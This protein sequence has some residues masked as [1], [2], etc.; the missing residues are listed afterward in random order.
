[1]TEKPTIL[2]AGGGTGG[3]L[4]PGIAVAE[5]LRSHL[6]TASICFVGSQRHLERTILNNIPFESC[7]IPVEPPRTFKR[8]P[9]RFL[10]QN[11]R[12]FQAA[13][14][15]LDE[16][17]PNVVVGLGSYIAAPVVIAASR[18]KIPVVLLEQNVIPGKA[19]RFLSRWA[20]TVCLAF[21]E[22]AAWFSGK[23]KWIVTGNPIRKPT[24]ENT[25]S[26]FDAEKK[27]LLI[28]GGSQGSQSVNKLAVES[29]GNLSHQ[30]K[31]WRVI[32]QTG[33]RR[34]DQV[35]KRYR[36]NGIDAVVKEFIA[37]LPSLFH[38]VDFVVSRAG[39]TTLAELSS[40]GCPTVLIPYPH[41]ANNHQLANAKFYATANAALI[42]E[43]SDGRVSVVQNLQKKIERLI[44]DSHLR[45]SMSQNMKKCSTPDATLRVADFIESFLDI[46]FRKKQPRKP[47]M[48]KDRI[49]K[50]KF[51]EQRPRFSILGTVK[52][53]GDP[54]RESK[55]WS[56]PLREGKNWSVP[57]REGEAPAEPES[58]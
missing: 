22:S 4:Y 31:N 40:A 42:V 38:R 39:A 46:S 47:Y 24:G 3:H 8:N 41:A 13:G 49:V 29:I 5:E 27:T 36:E 56:V 18:R 45:A 50:E 2:F 26:F 25:D 43:E 48:M 10:L 53:W 30:L 52:N 20:N 35:G 1:M 16:F 11:F 6:P 17:Q 12:A 23:T 32:H 19:N 54:L 21:E 37:D 7:I 15:I 44:D 33:Q 51:S 55:N 9:F 14:K 58:S 57:L 28:L 34:M